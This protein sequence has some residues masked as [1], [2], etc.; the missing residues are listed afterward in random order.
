MQHLASADVQMQ[1]EQAQWVLASMIP[2]ASHAV[3]HVENM[4]RNVRQRTTQFAV[5]VSNEAAR[6]TSH[7]ASR[8]MTPPPSSPIST[9]STNNSIFEADDEYS[10]TV[11]TYPKGGHINKNII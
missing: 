8:L 10:M 3:T 9:S 11:H 2:M 1:V 4:G 5:S 6:L 7:I